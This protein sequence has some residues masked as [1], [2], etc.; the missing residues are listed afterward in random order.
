MTA[1][2]AGP[3]ARWSS[4]GPA[5]S[6]GPRARSKGAPRRGTGRFTRGNFHVR[7]PG[8]AAE[9]GPRRADSG[10]AVGPGLTSVVMRHR[11]LPAFALVLA[12][13]IAV[14]GC[15]TVTAGTASNSHA[16]SASPSA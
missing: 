4:A 8:R 12:V 3:G 10:H 11:A 2:G 15:A 7:S 6:A 14:G 1:L 5:G 9:R 13:A 16:A